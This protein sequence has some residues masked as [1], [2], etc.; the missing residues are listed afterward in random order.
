[1]TLLSRF[2]VPRRWRLVALVMAVA[3]VLALLVAYKPTLSPPGLHERGMEFGV[4][5][6]H[7]L[8]DTPIS[9]LVDAD[10]DAIGPGYFPLTYALYLRTDAAR[11]AIALNAGVDARAVAASGPFT[12]LLFRPNIVIQAAV[13]PP[14]NLQDH[15]YRI[16]LDAT[17]GRP[18]LSI[19]AQAPT[20]A[21]ALALVH[22]TMDV[23]RE[24][25]AEEEKRSRVPATERPTLRFLG[26]AEG[27]QVNSGVNRELALLAFIVFSG[28]GITLLYRRERRLRRTSRPEDPAP[29]EAVPPAPDDWP[30]TTRLLPWAIAGFLAMVLVVPFDSIKLPIAIPMDGKLDRP[31]L[32]ALGILWVGALLAVRGA[33]APRIAVTRIH[34]AALAFFAVACL[35]AVLNAPALVNLDEFTLVLKKLVLLGSYIALF[36][37]VASVVRPAEA[38]RFVALLIGLAVVAA[39]GTVIEYR[40]G[41]N[42]FYSWSAALLP[43]SVGVPEDLNTLDSIGRTSIY[44]SAG[45]PVELATMVGMVV[46]FAVVGLLDSAERRRRIWY[47]VAIGVIFAGALATQRKTSIVAPAAGLLVLLAYRPRLVVRRLIPV[48]LVLGVLVGLAAPGAIQSIVDQLSPSKFGNVRSTQDRTA[49]YDGVAPDVTRHV[50]LGRGY[51]SYDHTKYRILDNAY[52]GLLVGVGVVGLL[53]YLAI[54]ATTMSAAHRTIRSGDPPLS[55]TA[56]AASASVAVVAVATLL[57]DVLSRPHVAYLFFFIAG[58]IAAM[59]AQGTLAAPTR[60]PNVILDPAHPPRERGR[61]LTAGSL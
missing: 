57:F 29:V 8:V 30:H 15:D 53:A 46:P 12:E 18:I 34:V 31:V 6:G 43:G 47:A 37:V 14:P 17:S 52:L 1:M 13:R 59:R 51:E 41:F 49:D 2:G 56:L 9:T 27:G 21:E 55:G 35:G 36:V 19:Y 60:N 7:I 50:L 16:V 22:S 32:A 61:T 20:S 39:F 5:K 26:A 28:A 38:P 25:V 24:H 23:L 54:L 11:A 58:L 40:L 48:G 10:Q 33:G 44:G 42:A 4:A 3:G 45:H